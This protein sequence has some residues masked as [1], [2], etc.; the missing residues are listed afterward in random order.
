MPRRKFPFDYVQDSLA[1]SISGA[2]S[3]LSSSRGACFLDFD[4]DG[5][6]DLFLVAA[7]NGK[8]RLLRNLGRGKFEDVTDKAGLANVGEG[9][10]L[11]CRR[12]R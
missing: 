3:P 5:K 12:F 6:P 9:L 7:G 4:S 11:R 1:K 8:S 10:R 2:T